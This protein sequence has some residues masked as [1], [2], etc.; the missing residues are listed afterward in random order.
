MMDWFAPIQNFNF[1]FIGALNTFWIT[2]VT[3]AISFAFGI[4]LA[5][6]RYYKKVKPT[7][8]LAT[9]Y[10]EVVR[11]TPVLVQIFLIYF[12]LPEFHIILS[13]VLAGI[14]A[15]SI[16]NAGYLSEIIRAGIIAVQS[17]QW[18]AASSLGIS[19]W[20]ILRHVIY[21]QAIRQ[22]FPAIANQ[23]LA[24]I[25]GTSLL[26][27]L[28]VRELMDRANILNSQTFQSMPIFM[29]VT[30]LYYVISIVVSFALKWVNRKYF[31]SYQKS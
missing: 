20:K 4:I 24:I 25:F 1:L 18:E 15:L 19:P 28:D 13:P 29:F 22:T 8:I 9:I 7:Y 11:N 3:F 27:V 30:L 26:S 14:I 21:P 2:L 23:F 10:V 5:T 6:A 17:G 12:G 16:N 31:P